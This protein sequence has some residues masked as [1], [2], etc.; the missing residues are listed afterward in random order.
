MN[1][2][3]VLKHHRG[4]QRWSEKSTGGNSA[5]FA[6]SGNSPLRRQMDSRLLKRQH[7]GLELETAISIYVYPSKDMEPMQLHICVCACAYMHKC[8]HGL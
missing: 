7:Y 4:I 3:V 8:M 6:N 5:D 1:L 2:D